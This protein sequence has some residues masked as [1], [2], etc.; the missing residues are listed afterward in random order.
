MKRLFAIALLILGALALASCHKTCT[1]KER[2]GAETTYSADYLDSLGITCTKMADYP[3]YEY[4]VL[5]SWD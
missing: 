3:V 4:R 2:N 1:C 5:C